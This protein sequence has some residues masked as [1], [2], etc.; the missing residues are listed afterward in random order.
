M[1]IHPFFFMNLRQP[2]IFQFFLIVKV[3]MTQIGNLGNMKVT[4]EKTL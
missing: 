4:E 3:R 1:S 2:L